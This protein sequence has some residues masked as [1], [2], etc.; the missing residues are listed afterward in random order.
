[1]ESEEKERSG[2]TF[3][4]LDR[5]GK[6]VTSVHFRDCVF[7][8]CDLTGATF[9]FCEFKDCS[10]ESCNLSLVKLPASSFSG[11]I[12]KDSKLIGINWTEAAWPKIQL[13]IPVQFDNC[14][15][16]DSVFLGLHLAGTRITRC[17]AKGA[18]F[19]D[20]DLSKA[21]LTRTDFSGALFGQTD[22]TGAN[23]DQ[24]R[25]YA[26]RV[27]D[28]RVKGASFSMPEA[29]ALLYCLDIKIL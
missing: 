21:D 24:A 7:R 15:L 11:T 17:L 6:A 2:E 27:A 9:R 19:R 10:F 23:L 25:N 18:D 1:M 13:A 28:N 4:G 26:I 5:K 14:L 16:N 22:L 8:N 3:T 12:F 20:A 29:M